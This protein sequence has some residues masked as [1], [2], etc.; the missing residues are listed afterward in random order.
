MEEEEEE[1]E[2]AAVVENCVCCVSLH[3]TTKSLMQLKSVIGF[4]GPFDSNVLN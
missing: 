2:S 4:G 3:R 1:A